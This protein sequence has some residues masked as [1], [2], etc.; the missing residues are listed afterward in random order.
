MESLVLVFCLLLALWCLTSNNTPVLAAFVR[1]RATDLSGSLSESLDR[2]FGCVSFGW[3]IDLLMVIMIVRFGVLCFG[4]IR[5]FV[6]L[7]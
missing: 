7:I 5:L 6:Y 4:V 1:L 2:S 3:L